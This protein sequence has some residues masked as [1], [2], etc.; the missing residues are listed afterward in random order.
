MPLD[1][2]KKFLFREVNKGMSLKFGEPK[3]IN[4]GGMKIIPIKTADS[5]PVFVK[6]G[7]YFSFGVKRDKNIK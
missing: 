6:T 4:V 7:K 3:S 2:G 1:E 5:K